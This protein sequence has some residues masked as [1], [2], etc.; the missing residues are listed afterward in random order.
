MLLQ[1]A[2]IDKKY[3]FLI[4]LGILINVALVLF[5]P[6][7]PDD[8]SVYHAL[9]CGFPAQHI[10]IFH[11]PCNSY[12]HQLGPF[13]Y[14]QDYEYV[15]VATSI[16]MGLML[17]VAG[18]LIAHYFWGLVTL[19]I[20]SLG[21]FKSFELQKN[22]VLILF[23]F[24]ITYPILHDDS[25]IRISIIFF[26]WTPFLL[27]KALAS[28]PTT[29][30]ILLTLISLG[31]LI[32][33]E[34]KPFFVYLL[35]GL[36]FLCLS[37][38]D[39]TSLQKISTLW[40]KITIFTTLF[41]PTLAFLLLSK[42]QGQSYLV[43]LSGNTQGSTNGYRRSLLTALL[44]LFS[45]FA[46]PVRAVNYNNSSKINHPEYLQAIPWGNGLVSILSLVILL[47]TGLVFAK[48]YFLYSKKI[49]NFKS[50]KISPPILQFISVV[51]LF[52]FP[53]LGGA[54]SG[55]HYVFAQ[56][57]ILIILLKNLEVF[58]KRFS[59][60]VIVGLCISVTG[61]TI[62][63]PP[64]SYNSIDSRKEI[65][66]AYSIATDNSIINCAYSCYFEYSLRNRGSV[67]VTFATSPEEGQALLELSKLRG[68]N[69]V[70]ICKLCS[71]RD[72]GSIFAGAKEVIKD[73]QYGVW[74]T[75]RITN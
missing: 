48:F 20:V 22:W 26:A 59:K 1:N 32:S 73:H 29:K 49:F 38:E 69:I 28:R 62:A 14:Q 52:G 68:S 50:L 67:P 36:F 63:T 55:H 72:V 45:W 31:W 24:P 35:P 6:S 47:F 30:F 10:N 75:F 21:L 58:F 4:F 17:H 39:Q 11:A 74:S 16:L 23:Y 51:L 57:A 34:D 3:L 41:I 54:W 40:K 37:L 15:G 53:I 27:R 19:A 43:F 7:H 13:N 8:F 25:P 12:F 18:P 70:H 66:F 5:I 9:A 65:D 56:V 46:Y 44:H 61:L 60:L 33:T 42:T 71:S 64:R 2:K